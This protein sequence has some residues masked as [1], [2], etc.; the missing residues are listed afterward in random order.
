MSGLSINSYLNGEMSLLSLNTDTR[1]YKTSELFNL[2]TNLYVSH[3]L[4][5]TFIS[6]YLKNWIIIGHH[7]G[8]ILNLY[9]LSNYQYCHYYHIFYYGL[10]NISNIYLSFMDIFKKDI[11]LI[12]K[13]PN[14][15]SIIRTLFAILFI[16]LRIIMWSYYSFYFIYDSS[17][18]Y[19][20][21]ESNNDLKNFLLI[22][23]LVIL[24][25][26]TLQFFW[27]KQIVNGV[28]KSLKKNK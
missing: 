27:A 14:L 18:I 16:F 22:N 10:T 12:S 17:I 13:F 7:L 21:E 5:A 11:I 8:C 3:N 25:F 20:K 15:Y 23:K 1:I 19:Y 28:V 24:I 9:Y 2:I 6:L 26:T 4:F